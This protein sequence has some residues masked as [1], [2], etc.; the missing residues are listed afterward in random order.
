M[1]AVTKKE[2]RPQRRSKAEELIDARMPTDTKRIIEQAATLVG[3]T[4]SDFVI[5]HAYQA[6]QAVIR[7]RERWVLN[8]AQSRAFAEALLN[9]PEPNEALT[10]AAER[11]KAR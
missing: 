10:R 11:Y 4:V 8:R 1:T 6:A 9:P 2:T 5:S 7:D 3:I